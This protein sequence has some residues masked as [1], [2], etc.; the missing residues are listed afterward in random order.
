MPSKN[1]QT[2]KVQ[3]CHHVDQEVVL[4]AEVIEPPEWMPYQMPRIVAHRC[5]QAILC[6]LDERPSCVW[7]GTNPIIDPFIETQDN[8]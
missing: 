5:S 6:N 4:E 1:W 7:A 2:I 8:P 3:F